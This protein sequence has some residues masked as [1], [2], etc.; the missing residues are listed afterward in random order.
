MTPGFPPPAAGTGAGIGAAPASDE[1]VLQAAAAHIVRA[2]PSFAR[3][4][5]AA[6]PYRPRP[7]EGS[8]FDA[9]ARAIV[10]QQLAGR[11]AQTIHGRFLALYGG[12]PSAG[13]VLQ[14]PLEDLRAVGL[15]GSKAASILDLAAKT[16]DGGPVPLERIEDLSD[17]EIVER[18]TAVRGIGRWTAEMFLIFHLHRLD[19]WPVDDFA[20]R[21]GY[22]I[23][24]GLSEAPKAKPLDAL[25]EP[26]RPYRSVAAWYCWRATDTVLPEA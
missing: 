24:H 16:A 21:K 14:T 15:S 9:L 3:V 20:V 26:F 11:A 1:A 2:D 13:A 23:I 12:R 22:G 17:A 5:A 6:G 19:V 18:L 4:V 25:G 10:Y 8:A 7:S